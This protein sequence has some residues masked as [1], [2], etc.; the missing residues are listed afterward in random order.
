MVVLFDI[1]DTLPDHN[2][3]VRAATNAL[4]NR[5]GIDGLCVGFLSKF[6]CGNKSLP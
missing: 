3:F 6:D 5:L 1:D 4:R 2:K